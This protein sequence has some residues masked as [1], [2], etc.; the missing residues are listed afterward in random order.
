MGTTFPVRIVELNGQPWFVA[1]DVCRALGFNLSAGAAP[2]MQK[3][4]QDERRVLKAADLPKSALGSAP[5]V[6]VVS[7]SGLYKLV[8]RSDKPQ[9]RL[10]QDWV[11]RDVLPAIRKDGAYIMG[12]EKVASGE[13]DE[14]EFVLKAIRRLSSPATTTATS[15]SS[16]LTA[17]ST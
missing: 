4:A 13:M 15:S 12:E 16:A 17:T 14:D 10:F 11:T 8:M 9:A 1:V 3:V 7:E 6:S 2:H 5:S